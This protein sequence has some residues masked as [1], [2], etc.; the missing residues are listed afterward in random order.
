MKSR[1]L[2][3]PVAAVAC[4]LVTGCGRRK[5]VTTPSTL[6]KLTVLVDF[7]RAGNAALYA[8]REDMRRA[9]IDAKVQVA[10]NDGAAIE[11][12]ASGQ[13][14]LASVSEA[15]LLQARDR[16]LRVVSVGGLV[17]GP[18]AAVAS[19]RPLSGA[20]DLSGKRVGLTD[21][22]Y[23]AAFAK[24]IGARS[25]SPLKTSNVS[26]NPAQ[27][28]AKHKVDA[29]LGIYLDDPR[30]P[31]KK[32]SVATV[33]RFGIPTYDELVLVAN[34]D[35]LGRNGD[36]FRALNGA[37]QRAD[38]K[39]KAGQSAGVPTGG[40]ALKAV[41]PRLGSQQV[42]SQWSAFAEWMQANGLLK[43]QL[44]AGAAFTNRYLPGQGL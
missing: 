24:T 35:A 29:V 37:L 27:A 41:V 1:S 30:L 33:D 16:G 10:R 4:L 19:G 15:A 25:G 21:S 9:G 20:R 7:Q 23:A 8:G 3:L 39:L 11:S 12:V 43:H 5:E 44:N 17:R 31:S 42:P 32:V 38:A 18:L 28:L 34:E 13:A 2:L 40:T 22:P 36:T 14:D 6:Q 26:S